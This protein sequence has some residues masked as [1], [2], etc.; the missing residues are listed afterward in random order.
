MIYIKLD[1]NKETTV[2]VSRNSETGLANDVGNIIIVA[3]QI[4]RRADYS[5]KDAIME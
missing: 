5:K 4:L 2:K 1:E 3:Y